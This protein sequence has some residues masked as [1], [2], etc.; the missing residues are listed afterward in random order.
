MTVAEAGK[1]LYEAASAAGKGDDDFA[2]V[3]EAIEPQ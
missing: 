2:A 1:S 3:I